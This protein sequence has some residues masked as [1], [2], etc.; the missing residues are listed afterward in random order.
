MLLAALDQRRPTGDVDLLAKDVANDI[1]T[2]SDLVREVLR[3][4]FDDGVVFNVEELRAQVIRDT[5][6]YSGVRIVVPAT[7]A[8]ARHPLRLDVNVGDPVTPSPVEIEFPALLGEPFT[9]IGYPIETVL[10]EKIVTMIDRGDTTTRERDFADVILLTR[11]HRIEAA[12]L[13]RAVRVTGAH[14]QSDLRSLRIVLSALATMRHAD[15][16][17]FVTRSGLTDRVPPSYNEAIEEVI[18]F[19]DPI[20]TGAIT[21]GSW[22]PADRAWT[23]ASGS[24]SKP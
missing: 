1:G 19:A 23:I 13:A 2:V 6:L 17:R 10:A 5:D 22:N 20:V 11:R 3:L 16:D 4:E 9:I 15:W 8:R 12:T 24:S 18:I 14:R 7:V 21:S